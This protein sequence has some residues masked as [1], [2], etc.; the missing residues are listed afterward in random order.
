MNGETEMLPTIDMVVHKIKTHK[1]LLTELTN[2]HKA[3]Q[4]T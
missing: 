4:L 2:T 3:N 1:Q